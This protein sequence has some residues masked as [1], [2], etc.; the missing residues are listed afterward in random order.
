MKAKLYQY[1]NLSIYKGK[2]SLVK[3]ILQPWILKVFSVLFILVPFFSGPFGSVFLVCWKETFPR[4]FLVIN[5]YFWL[6]KLCEK[7]LLRWKNVGS[8][9]L[10]CISFFMYLLFSPHHNY[11]YDF[12]MLFYSAILEKKNP[13]WWSIK[14]FVCCNFHEIRHAPLTNME[15]FLP[16]LTPFKNS[17]CSL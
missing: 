8:V 12:E 16:F 1:F 14:I 17:Y 7:N 10:M 4:F 15:Y 6:I 11:F 5:N 9:Y 2:V 3:D 13:F